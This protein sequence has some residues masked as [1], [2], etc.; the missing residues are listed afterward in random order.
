MSRILAA[1]VVALV[2]C[3]TVDDLVP[4]YGTVTCAGERKEVNIRIDPT[5]CGAC[6]G[7]G[8]VCAEG[9]ACID[10]ECDYTSVIHCGAEGRSCMGEGAV[11]IP[12]PEGTDAELPPHGEV[13]NG[14]AC[15]L[16]PGDG[17]VDGGAGDAG[18]DDEPAEDVAERPAYGAPTWLLVPGVSEGCHRGDEL[19]CHHA[20]VSFTDICGQVCAPIPLDYDYRVMATEMSRAQYRDAVCDCT[21]IETQQCAD[22]CRP[23]KADRDAMPMTGLNWCMA[24]AACEAIGGRLPTAVE[25]ARLEQLASADRALFSDANCLDWQRRAGSQPRVGECIDLDGMAE[26]VDVDDPR[27][28]MGAGAGVSPQP[29]TLY[30]SLGNA[31]EWL[32]DGA[33]QIRCGELEDGDE[34]RLRVPGGWEGTAAIQGRSVM[35]PRGEPVTQVAI[36][37]ST[38]AADLGVRCVQA[39]GGPSL[40]ELPLPREYCNFDTP[41]GLGAVRRSTS[42]TLYRAVGV[43]PVTRLSGSR[44]RD[45][46][47]VLVDALIHPETPLVWRTGDE[48][49]IGQ[50]WFTPDA[51][52]WIGQPGRVGATLSFEFLQRSPARL[53][54]EQYS[55]VSSG[56]CVDQMTTVHPDHDGYIIR[57]LDFIV[58]NE[59]LGRVFTSDDPTQIACT[60]LECAVS[61]PGVCEACPAWR[62]PIV[63]GF[64]RIEPFDHPDLCE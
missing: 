39:N 55:L 44:Y 32:L 57:Q 18:I 34:T 36:S 50:A 35:S 2:G 26:L 19:R 54:W 25:R 62:L 17:G 59:Q 27:G 58:E 11:C 60:L 48:A 4:P 9:V 21:Y 37:P 16:V 56:S 51:Q 53:T 46:I 13:V 45:K 15:A 64:E 47:E 30:H 29:P 3:G 49:E 24:Q 14:Y 42:D 7:I 28:A 40:D 1:G 12:V 63:V 6:P 22:V 38:R 10:F 31:S 41:L 8:A 33:A 20:F 5:A 23:E 61:G 52:W 43:C